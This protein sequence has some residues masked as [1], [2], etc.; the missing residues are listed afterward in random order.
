MIP[1]RLCAL[2]QTSSGQRSFPSRPFDIRPGKISC[3][4]R[5]HSYPNFRQDEN[6]TLAGGRGTTFMTLSHGA[7]KGRTYHMRGIIPSMVVRHHKTDIHELLSDFS[8]L[9]ARSGE[10]HWAFLA[11]LPSVVHS[12]PD[13]HRSESDPDRC[14]ASFRSSLTP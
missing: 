7:P 1:E 10:M 6:L 12:Q 13:S 4:K 11:I 2:S 3:K 14:K 8:W 5:L 9:Q